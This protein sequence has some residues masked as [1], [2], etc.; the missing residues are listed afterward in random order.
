M[1]AEGPR[2]WRAGVGVSVS[3]GA[4]QTIYVR[5]G[6]DTV[7]RLGRKGEIWHPPRTEL[8][9]L[10]AGT[11]EDLEKPVCAPSAPG[12][13]RWCA[14]TGSNLSIFSFTGPTPAYQRSRDQRL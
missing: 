4:M 9:V 1:R 5:I 11:A 8:E 3:G 10:C 7:R 6:A 12:I 14:R 13:G 2:H